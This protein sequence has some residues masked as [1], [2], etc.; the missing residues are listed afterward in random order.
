MYS[1]NYFIAFC[2]YLLVHFFYSFLNFE[3]FMADMNTRI[4]S[5]DPSSHFQIGTYVIPSSDLS[6]FLVS[7][8]SSETLP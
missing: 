7:N 8:I 5:P 3:G 1:M 2:G 4:Y 6:T